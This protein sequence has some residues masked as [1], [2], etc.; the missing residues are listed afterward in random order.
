MGDGGLHQ[1][2]AEGDH[3]HMGMIDTAADGTTRSAR[4][5]LERT[6]IAVRGSQM[7]GDAEFEGPKLIEQVRC[8]HP[9]RYEVSP[10]QE[11]QPAFDQ[12]AK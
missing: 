2:K 9:H 7:C 1:V 3:V 5:M 12:R 10:R 8:Q 11:Q 4:P 6:N